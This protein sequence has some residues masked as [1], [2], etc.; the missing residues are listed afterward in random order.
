VTKHVRPAIT[1]ALLGGLFAVT[2]CNAES[3]DAIGAKERSSP[4]ASPTAAAPAEPEYDTTMDTVKPVIMA[5]AI[6]HTSK[7]KALAAAQTAVKLV[8]EYS[9]NADATTLSWDA[10]GKHA[11]TADKYIKAEVAPEWRATVAGYI[12]DAKADVEDKSEDAADYY[13]L[14]FDG[15]LNDTARRK[16]KYALDDGPVL[17]NPA[18]VKVQ[19]SAAPNG[20]QIEVLI[21]SRGD[22]RL[23]RK[24]KKQVWPAKRTQT[25]WMESVNGTWK[26]DGWRG[27]YATRGE[28]T[29][30][31]DPGPQAS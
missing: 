12:A 22:Y 19:A 31:P 13:S 23:T 6:V 14:V 1:A 24:G 8:T 11:M 5:S 21:V 9:W 30:V 18:I 4:A 2:G 3:D 16:S 25:F 17:V 27:S 15:M 29:Y 7:K 26:V 28:K 20:E 10:A